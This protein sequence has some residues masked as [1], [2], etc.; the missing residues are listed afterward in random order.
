MASA[1]QTRG[2]QGG[3]WRAREQENPKIAAEFHWKVWKDNLRT[4]V[5]AGSSATLSDNRWMQ[6][7]PPPPLLP[8][9]LGVEQSGLLWILRTDPQGL[10]C[11]TRVRTKG[12]LVGV[13]AKF[14]RIS[15]IQRKEKDCPQNMREVDTAWIFQ[16]ARLFELTLHRN[17][18]RERQF[19]VT[20]KALWTQPPSK[21][22][23]ETKFTWK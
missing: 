15:K 2:S 23:R 10:S 14:N 20:A 19:C 9:G 18:T 11:R 17:N 8:P 13:K 7:S 3:S 6:A 22:F 16:R 1:P 21:Q 4:T 12:K 5:E